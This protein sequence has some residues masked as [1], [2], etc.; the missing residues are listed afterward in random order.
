MSL[1]HA[2]AGTIAPY[3]GLEATQIWPPSEESAPFIVSLWMVLITY[4]YTMFVRED[5]N[6]AFD[7]FIKQRRETKMTN[8]KN[9][10]V[11]ENA[12][13]AKIA[14]K[15]NGSEGDD[16]ADDLLCESEKPPTAEYVFGVVFER[17]EDEPAA[18]ALSI[19]EED[20]WYLR[21][22]T[23]L[24]RRVQIEV[25]EAKTRTKKAQT[26]AYSMD[27]SKEDQIVMDYQDGEKLAKI[28]EFC[29]EDALKHFGYL[30]PRGAHLRVPEG[31][32]PDVFLDHFDQEYING[33]CEL[34]MLEKPAFRDAER[35]LGEVRAQQRNALMFIFDIFW[36]VMP[37][38]MLAIFFML[39]ARA[40]EAP[41][42][43]YSLPRYKNSVAQI[44]PNALAGEFGYGPDMLKEA[45]GHAIL[46]IV[47]FLFSRPIEMLASSYGDRAGK[48]FSQPLRRAVMGAIM[49]QDSEFFDFNSSSVLQER[50]NRDTD[51]LVEN[52]LWLPRQTLEF[53]FRV[54]QRIATLY[55]VAPAMLWACLSFNVPL[56]TIVI[57]ATSRP[58]NRFYS[59]RDRSSEN[60]QAETLEILQ[61]ILTVRQ[62]SM[63]EREKDKYSLGNLSRGV[64]EGRIRVLE[65]LTHN[66]RFVIHIVGE[67]FVIYTALCLCVEGKAEVSDAIVASTVGMW[68]QHDMK[69]LMENI[70]KLL[71]MT[72]PIYRVTALLAC[73]PRIEND[74][75]N[76]KCKLLRPKRFQGH[77][78][79]K[80]VT[81]SYPKERQKMVLNGLSFTAK[82]GQKI[83][84][85]GK[86]GCGKSTSMDL[87]QRFYN[88]TGG[89][90]RIDGKLIEEYDTNTLR[91]HCGV[92]SQTNVLFAR[93]IYENIVYGMEDPPGPE[94]E[95][96]MEVCKM[97]EAWEFIAKFANKQYTM[98][99]EKGA[100]LSGGQKQRIAIA[101]VII[102]QPTFLFLDEA[103][104]ALDAINEKAV[105]VALDD[106]LSQFKGVAIVVAHRLTTIC[107]CDKIV[108]MGD[109][110]TKVEEGTHEE[111][112][113]V[114]KQVDAEGKPVAGPGLYHTL[115]D[116]QQVSGKTGANDNAGGGDDEGDLKS[117]LEAQEK[118]LEDLRKELAWSKL[119]AQVQL[120]GQVKRPPSPLS[121]PP[122]NQHPPLKISNSTK[123]SLLAL[124]HRR[125]NANTTKAW[126]MIKPL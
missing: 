56:F 21:G 6:A 119:K 74:P 99:G 82:P 36:P 69:N 52:L 111:L 100:R 18:K 67:L 124:A 23:L 53:T 44:N 39:V 116:T 108:V 13:L 29:R 93:S 110:G 106:M 64:F 40:F 72:K 1:L 103:T 73:K 120:M 102:R 48:M 50:L 11:M 57:L 75:S 42:W 49:K 63:E 25:E 5:R 70:P 47:G 125:S 58:L 126:K 115:W 78:E 92:V 30:S 41:L 59:Q 113:K 10:V 17:I 14:T 61:N 112:L 51:E 90:I 94:S 19:P 33:A 43:A 71:K 95:R 26:M 12:R 37:T 8:I 96:F 101:R 114:P 122:I 117:K 118:E 22:V 104:S 46:F 121:T 123:Q 62:F 38:Y 16:G 60:S 77:I 9:M 32:I 54:I 34:N 89:E 7:K 31:S 86:A 20:P 27:V 24:K 55:F 85:V 83:A 68:L 98:I 35:V 45:E 28:I 2:A 81:F 84:F 66:L 65:T 88:R 3:L 79:F 107:N 97:A 91:Q 76:P 15:Q 4:L 80:Q 109:D 105:Q 87:L